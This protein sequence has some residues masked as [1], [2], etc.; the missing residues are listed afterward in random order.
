MPDG[1]GDRALEAVW[2]KHDSGVNAF[3][4]L[5]NASQDS[6]DVSVE[7]TGSEGTA[8][9]LQGDAATEEHGNG[10]LGPDYRG[11]SKD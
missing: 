1:N 8:P 6:K 9:K 4:A 10:G 3:L 7:I 2:W 11:T 5:S